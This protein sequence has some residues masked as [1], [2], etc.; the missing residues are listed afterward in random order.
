MYLLLIEPRNP[1]FSSGAILHL[2][3]AQTLTATWPQQL[4]LSSRHSQQPPGRNQKPPKLVFYD[5]WHLGLSL[6]LPSVYGAAPMGCLWTDPVR[7]NGF[8]LLC[9]FAC[10]PVQETFVLGLRESKRRKELSTKYLKLWTEV[11]K[12]KV[13]RLPRENCLLEG[14]NYLSL[15]KNE[16]EETEDNKCFLWQRNMASLINISSCSYFIIGRKYHYKK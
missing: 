16:S 7:L 13:R 9:F 10:K 14:M 12:G 2:K 8:L 15:L 11:T 3:T 5:S 6:F 1:G 4:F